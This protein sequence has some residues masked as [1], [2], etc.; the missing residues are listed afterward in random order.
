MMR[1]IAR[2]VLCFMLATV[3]DW[4]PEIPPLPDHAVAQAQFAP[5]PASGLILYSG[6]SITAVN[7]TNEVSMFQFLV[8]AGLIATAVSVGAVGSPIYTGT[9]ASGLST[10]PLTTTPA[11]IHF[12]AEGAIAGAAG[13]T[14]NLGINFG[15]LTPAIDLSPILATLVLNNNLVSSNT[16]YT[17]AFMDVWLQPIATTSATPNAVNTAYFTARFSWVNASGTLTTTNAATVTNI[18]LASPAQLNIVARWAAAATG[19]SLIFFSR[20][21]AIGR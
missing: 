6:A 7:T 17:P 10:V 14:V 16:L 15:S 13:T 11:P 21:L 5:I 2:I 4:A 19:S 1:K 20:T 3:L 9:S 12:H 18:N 8:P